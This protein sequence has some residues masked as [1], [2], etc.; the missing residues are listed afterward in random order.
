MAVIATQAIHRLRGGAQSLLMLG[1]DGNLWVVKFQNN[2]QHLRVLANELIAT[3]LAEAVG[4]S[5]P[6]TDVIEVSPWLIANSPEMVVE[7]R[8]NVSEPCAAGLQFGSQFV[9]GL[10]PGQVVDYLPESQMAE[11]RNLAEFAGIFCLDK[12][13]GNCNGRQAVFERR[14]RERRYR[15]IFIDQGFCFNAGEWTFP[16]PVLRGVFPRNY[17]YAGVTGWQS[18]EPWLSR[19]EEFAE[20]KLWQIAEAVPPE[21]YGGDT[22]TIEQL[23]QT[24]LQRRSG[25]R[26]GI[27]AFRESQRNP[28]PNWLPSKSV[29]VAAGVQQFVM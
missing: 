8:R 29:A 16:D 2:P 14:P 25:V 24:L 10:N 26:E 9:G 6:K 17:V 11:L 12:W 22:A 20:S 4:L 13:T 21:W 18:F 5:V 23:M 19:I 28:F 15:A 7:R 3:R 27:T 1:S